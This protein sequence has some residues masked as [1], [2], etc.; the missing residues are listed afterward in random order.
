MRTSL[1][2]DMSGV[3]KFTHLEGSIP[4]RENDGSTD[5]N[6]PLLLERP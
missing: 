1:E 4:H 2:V 5:I 6:Q 3:R